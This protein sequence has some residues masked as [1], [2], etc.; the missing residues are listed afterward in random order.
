MGADSRRED[1][2]LS[3][4]RAVACSLPADVTTALEG[5]LAAEGDPRARLLLGQALRNGRQAQ[6][7]GLPL[8][9]DRGRPVF[10]IADEATTGAVKRAARRAR[11]QGWVGGPLRVVQGGAVPQG[12]I[13]VLVPG[14]SPR[15]AARA[16]ALPRGGDEGALAEAV[17]RAVARAQGLLCPPLLVGV[18][19]GARRAQARLRALQ[20]LLR[21]LDAPPTPLEGPLTAAVGSS[22]PGLPLLGLRVQGVLPAR[23]L[24]VEFLCRSARRRL[25]AL[26]PE[27]AY[28]RQQ[29]SG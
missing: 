17:A 29:S 19:L 27:A 5:A 14:R 11:A 4:L 22:C 23:Y 7:E 10:F 6:A 12:C 28:G 8:C 9:E 20:A 3:L 2:L 15:R 18:G 13:G 21:P 24:A 16:V 26:S 25:V 1:A